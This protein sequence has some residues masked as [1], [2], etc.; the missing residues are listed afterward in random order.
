MSIKKSMS[1]YLDNK[2]NKFKNIAYKNPDDD[3]RVY[4]LPNR[5]DNRPCSACGSTVSVKYFFMDRKDKSHLLC[6][7]C[8][9]IRDF[10]CAYENSGAHTK[11]QFEK[12]QR[13]INEFSNK[14]GVVDFDFE[15]MYPSELRF[16]TEESFEKVTS[17][18]EKEAKENEFVYLFCRKDYDLNVNLDTLEELV[19]SFA[20]DVEL[21]FENIELYILDVYE[22][23]D[24]AY[25]AMC[26]EHRSL[27]SSIDHYIS[28]TKSQDRNSEFNT[29][30]I[31]YVYDIDHG[32]I[33]IY[34]VYKKEII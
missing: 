25:K 10:S 11:E 2:Y 5:T 6:N 18:E 15:S 26:L 34:I 12:V 13:E 1:D 29:Y 9:A 23:R 22:N 27:A 30:D 33:T 28:G 3:I 32:D 19:D 4:P 7:R 14:P 20:K 31:K 17:E 21:S 24:T 8:A 16:N